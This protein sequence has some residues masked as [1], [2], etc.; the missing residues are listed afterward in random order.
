MEIRIEIC[1]MY[2]NMYKNV[3]AE[4]LNNGAVRLVLTNEMT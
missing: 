1:N 4:A 3:A 2:R